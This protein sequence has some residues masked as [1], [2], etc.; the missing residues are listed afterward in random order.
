MLSIADQPNYIAEKL[1]IGV[2]LGTL[3]RGVGAKVAFTS[4]DNMKYVSAGYLAYSSSYR[5]SCGM[6]LGADWIEQ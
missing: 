2:G 4:D 1:K 3:Y 5:S 6:E